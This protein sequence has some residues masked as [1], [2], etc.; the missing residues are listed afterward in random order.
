MIKEVSA[1]PTPGVAVLILTPEVVVARMPLAIMMA[2][3]SRLMDQGVGHLI[4]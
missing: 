4:N 2:I 1:L 3:V